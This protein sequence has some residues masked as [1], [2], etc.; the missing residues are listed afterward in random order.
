MK[1]EKDIRISRISFYGDEEIPIEGS[2]S[3]LARELGC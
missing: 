1:D 2:V 3:Q